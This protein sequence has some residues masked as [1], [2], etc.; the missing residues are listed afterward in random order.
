MTSMEQIFIIV[1][2]HGFLLTFLV[3][4]HLFQRS[5]RFTDPYSLRRKITEEYKMACFSSG[6]NGTNGKFYCYVRF[7]LMS[8]SIKMTLRCGQITKHPFASLYVSIESLISTS[9]KM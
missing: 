3:S 9:V 4:W 5:S 8:N 1:S 6:K 7:I 2:L